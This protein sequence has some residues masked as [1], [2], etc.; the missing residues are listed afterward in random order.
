MIYTITI[1]GRFPS[2]NEYI[3]A[4]R[5]HKQKGNKMRKESEYIIS[6]YIMQQLRK[7]HIDKPVFIRYRFF[8]PNKKRDLDNISGYFHKVFQDSLVY[9]NVIHNDSWQY[10][11]GFQDIFD[12]DNKHPRIEVEIIEQGA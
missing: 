12:V 10:I 6:M 1:D 3:E 7:V 9:N 11:T 8:E 5:A 2:L 4:N